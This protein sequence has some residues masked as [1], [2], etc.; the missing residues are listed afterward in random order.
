MEKI[1]FTKKEFYDMVWATPLS[2]L[3]M[4]YDMSD[5]GLRKI[6]KKY[7]IPIPA[8]GYWQKLKHNKPVLKQKYKP[9]NNDNDT[10]QLTLRTEENALNAEKS[11]LIALTNTIKEDK[12]APLEVAGTLHNMHPLI[13]KTREFWETKN[14]S[15]YLHYEKIE[16]LNVRAEPDNRSRALRIMNALIRL[17]EYRGHSIRVTQHET[18]AVIH[19]V[20]INLSLREATKRIPPTSDRPYDTGVYVPVGELI[21]KAGKWSKEKEWRDGKTKL[22]TLLARFVAWLEI[23]A[24]HE[25]ES[26]ERTRLWHIEYEAKKKLE[27][28]EKQRRVLEAKKYEE[29]LEQS[30]RYTKA[31]QLRYYIE[32]R[33]N[34]KEKE[35]DVSPDFYQWLRWANEKADLLDPLINDSL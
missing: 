16:I 25:L 18:F 23:Y 29:L 20:D 5:N 12:K 17:L 11:P 1:S 4:I 10:I 8:N 6:C 24:Q 9:G 27:D 3:S 31:Q 35:N 33:R 34:K 30:E 21:L 2:R 14:K 22:E 26:R 15:D 19:D 28:E 32:A 7:S 13:A